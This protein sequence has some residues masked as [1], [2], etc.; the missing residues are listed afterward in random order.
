MSSSATVP[1]DSTSNG[2]ASR[3][4]YN[5]RLK[6]V[7][8]SCELPTKTAYAAL[9]TTLSSTYSK[10]TAQK[11]SWRH[12][13][14]T[15]PNKNLPKMCSASLLS[16]VQ[17]STEVE[18]AANAGKKSSKK[19]KTSAEARPS[20]V[21]NK[22]EEPTKRK[23]P[24][25]RM[26]PLNGHLRT[27]K[28]LMLP[29]RTQVL[30]LKRC[31]S[32]ARR[33][34]NQTLARIKNGEPVNFINL[35][36]AF[37]AEP[38]PEWAS[39]KKAVASSILAGAQKQATDA[40]NTNLKKKKKNPNHRFEVKFRSTKRTLTE[41]IKIEKDRYNSDKKHSTLLAFRP[42][43][44]TR[45][46]E[47]LAFFGNNLKDVGGIRLQSSHAENIE[48]MVAEGNR[49]KEDAKIHYDKRT[50]K[51]RFVFTFEAPQVEDLDPEFLNKRVVATDP[52]CKAFHIKRG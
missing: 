30:E 41:V 26:A 8:E 48:R 44:Y 2:K 50:N 12:T 23:T 14:H 20:D 34:Y 24:F 11:S 25:K 9:H 49:L 35:Q 36:K 40:Y 3:R 32:A 52:G 16:L 29:T 18:A 1:L 27:Y 45:R 7:Y 31:F 10:S 22:M 43:P 51:F 39:G 37:R 21:E 38:P 46:P 33:A 13:T 19:Q 15:P 5:S 42:V 4:F 28:V 47:C 17:G 6:N